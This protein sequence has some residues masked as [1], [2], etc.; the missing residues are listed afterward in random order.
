MLCY[1][2]FVILFKDDYESANT[3]Q[4]RV[5]TL[6]KIFKNSSPRNNEAKQSHHPPER[7]SSVPALGPPR[8]FE[9]LARMAEVKG[10]LDKLRVI[11]QHTI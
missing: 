1:N 6:S 5:A 10:L 2:I 7:S 8:G 4:K 11:A 3:S 9:N